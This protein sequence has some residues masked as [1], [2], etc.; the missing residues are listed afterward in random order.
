MAYQIPNQGDNYIMSAAFQGSSSYLT[1][2]LFSNDV[3]LTATMAS[4]D[5]TILTAGGYAASQIHKT[6]W[7]IPY[8]SAGSAEVSASGNNANGF[9]FS[10][11]AAPN[12]SAFGYVI[13]NTAVGTGIC[14]V[15]E[16]FASSYY[17]ANAGDTI[18]IK[19]KVRAT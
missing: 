5:C 4:S 13:S 1:L 9:Q 17:L 10:F 18:T 2:N 16:K 14:I 3:S 6:A 12:Q 15:V 7:C 8:L 11:T 19:P